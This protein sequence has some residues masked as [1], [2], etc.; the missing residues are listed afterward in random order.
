MIT[1]DV[2]TIV[3]YNTSPVHSQN[4]SDVCASYYFDIYNGANVRPV[5]TYQSATGNVWLANKNNPDTLQT[6]NA[7][8]KAVAS[9]DHTWQFKNMNAA[10]SPFLGFGLGTVGNND[11]TPNDFMVN[12][13]GNIDYSL[14]AGDVTTPNLNSKVLVKDHIT[15]TFTG[16]TGFT[17]D[18]ISPAF[19][20]GL[21]TR[22][23]SLL[24]TPEP[25]TIV[26]LLGVSLFGL[27]RRVRRRRVR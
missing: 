22:P 25:A 17:E 3:F 2:L 10:Q 14:Y 11:L 9:G 1:G 6:A 12:I 27:H 26:P 18:D 24:L 8:L 5:L 21:G 20:V 19:A 23:D 13:V 15:F 4:P 7:N 16:L